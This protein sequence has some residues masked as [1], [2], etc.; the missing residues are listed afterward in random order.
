MG[1]AVREM[2]R[3]HGRIVNTPTAFE[4]YPSITAVTYS[5]RIFTCIMIGA[6]RFLFWFSNPPSLTTYYVLYLTEF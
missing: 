2:Q 4:L 5:A 3:V 6:P 1:K